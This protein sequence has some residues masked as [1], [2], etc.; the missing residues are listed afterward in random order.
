[1]WWGTGGVAGLLVPT[2][3]FSGAFVGGL[4]G[5][6]WHGGGGGID[7]PPDSMRMQT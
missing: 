5:G 6:L 2:P 7:F 1:M 3:V 4:G